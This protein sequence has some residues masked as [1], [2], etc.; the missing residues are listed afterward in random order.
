MKVGWVPGE[1]TDAAASFER[2]Q[3]EIDQVG[4]P[5]GARHEVAPTARA[6]VAVLL[7]AGRSER[8]ERITGG[9]S[10]ALNRLAGISLVERAI[11]SLLGSGIEEVLVVVGYHAGPVAAVVGDIAPGRVRTVLAE[12]WE[13]G[14]GASLAAAALHVEDEGLFVVMMA[15]HVFGDG[16]LWGLL[17]SDEPA[18]LVDP[19]PSAEVRGE[20]TRVRIEEGDAVAFGKA[21]DEP[22][23]DCG[24]FV[25]S[26]E[27]FECQR[28]AALEGDATLAGAVT[29]F[30]EQRPLRARVVPRGTWWHDIDTP[31]NLVQAR[32]LL[33]W[34]LPKDGDGPVSRFLNRPLSTRFSLWI[35]PAR[36]SPDLLSWIAFLFGIVAAASLAAG[37]GIT[38]GIL[39]QV[40]S[41]LDGMD[42]EAARLQMRARPQGALLDGVLDR[43]TDAAILGGLGLW[44]L[45]TMPAA[46]ASVLLVTLAA[47]F[48]SVM[49]MASKDRI[50]AHGLPA[51]DERTLSWLLGGRDGRMLLVAILSIPLDRRPAACGAGCGCRDV[52]PDAGPSG[53]VRVPPAPLSHSSVAF[54]LDVYDVEALYFRGTVYVDLAETLQALGRGNGTRE[55]AKQR[56]SCSNARGAS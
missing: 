8:L 36:L 15:D 43:V 55:A 2:G 31:E 41:V 49:S 30:A 50:I 56:S 37:L 25:L 34:S 35:S 6:R 33:R 3:M 19:D 5:S 39:A 27:I 1:R 45:H 20:G 44:T 23:V 32:R 28:L 22:A 14:N 42:G 7:A 10:K 51:A 40:T 9:G 13:R 18:V 38:G 4:A 11:R 12:D 21:L 16:G 54:T 46:S 29:L 24:V 17:Q 26:A 53:R 52:V 47:V 48:G